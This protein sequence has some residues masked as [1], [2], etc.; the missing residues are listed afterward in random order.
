MEIIFKNFR[1]NIIVLAVKLV[2]YSSWWQF[3][4]QLVDNTVH[5]ILFILMLHSWNILY[6]AHYS[7][8]AIIQI[9][10]YSKLNCWLG[11]S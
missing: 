7:E 8:C 2:K 10:M 6:R 4:N 3:Y 11:I 5:V 9:K 1:K